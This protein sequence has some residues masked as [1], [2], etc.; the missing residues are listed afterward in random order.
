[1]ENEKHVSHFPTASNSLSHN[2]NTRLGRAIALPPEAALRAR[3]NR[4]I[5]KLGNILA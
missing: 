3:I 1:V 5:Y 4:D 2:K